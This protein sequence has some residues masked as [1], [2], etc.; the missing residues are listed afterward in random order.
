MALWLGG[1]GLYLIHWL[2]APFDWH[3]HDTGG[4]IEY[5]T[6]IIRHLK[7]PPIFGGWTYY[8]PPAYYSLSAIFL[9]FSA[10]LLNAQAFFA[11]GGN[12]SFSP[13]HYKLLQLTSL[14]WYLG[15]LF[16]MRR[17][18]TCC[19][20]QKSLSLIALAIIIVWPIGQ[21]IATRIGNDLPVYCFTAACIY[22][23]LEW[24]ETKN[25]DHLAYATIV[26]SFSIAFK[27]S[28]LVLFAIIFAAILIAG[29]RSFF[30]KDNFRK[31]I[32]WVSVVVALVC[33]GSNFGR[34]YYA[35]YTQQL[36]QSALV[37]NA[38]VLGSS[39]RVGN[40]AR[41]FL[42][43]DW[44]NYLGRPYYHPWEDKGGRQYFWNTFLKSSLFGEF[45]WKFPVLAKLLGAL[46]LMM[47]FYLLT[48]ASFIIPE[49]SGQEK[50]R[51]GLMTT[52]IIC[53]VAG[54]IFLRL[55]FPFSCSNDARYIFP[56]TGLFAILYMVVVHKHLLK[57]RMALG[58]IGLI[59]GVV[60][61]DL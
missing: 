15:Y 36:Q 3:G 12:T 33:A 27:S 4:H 17:I 61:T 44:E 58:L 18:I 20:H 48:T 30:Q 52:A 50:R 7:I 51:L 2:N 6:Y 41:N 38:Q 43:F 59:A 23:L 53:L 14:Y 40:E 26:A 9:I 8:H 13:D 31:S 28:G 37:G 42:H 32:F 1:L 24:L 5:M 16:F 39:L 45:D 22:F 29:W 56:A 19:I 10:A 35:K 49:L 34:T 55:Q 57:Q 21:I 11:S 25:F 46:F 47:I 60:F 54:L